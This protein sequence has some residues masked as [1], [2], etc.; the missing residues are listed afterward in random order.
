MSEYSAASWSFICQ[1]L[2]SMWQMYMSLA[3]TG[4][5]AV[6]CEFS[7]WCGR[8][9]LLLGLEEAT[10]CCFC[11]QS[12]TA[13]E[14]RVQVQLRKD[15]F[16]HHSTH[17]YCAAVPVENLLS[18]WCRLFGDVADLYMVDCWNFAL[19]SH[20]CGVDVSIYIAVTSVW[21]SPVSEHWGDESHCVVFYPKNKR[22]KTIHF[23]KNA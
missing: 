12:L 11:V 23:E 17:L 6:E 16:L 8:Y 19:F 3:S 15:R 14:Q 4:T 21:G 18:F 13:G 7:C 2:P 1:Y 5:R 10:I 9:D 20:F 22:W